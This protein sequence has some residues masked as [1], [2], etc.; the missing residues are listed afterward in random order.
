MKASAHSRVAPD[1]I[2]LTF[3]DGPSRWTPLA[4]DELARAETRATFFVTPGTDADLVLRMLADGHE[5]GYHCGEHVR[6]SERRRSEVRE[7]ARS[8][9]DWLEKLG[10]T[11]R[12]WRPPWGVLADWS[13]ELAAELDLEIWLWSDDTNDWDGRSTQ[14]M[15][16]DLA[17][18]IGPG[19]VVLMHDGLGPGCRRLDPMATVALI[20]PLVEL[21]RGLELQP[22]ILTESIAAHA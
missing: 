4:L 20:A 1:R 21:C 11:P 17:D 5:V 18:S 22:D 9:L 7:E 8:G 14:M 13:A 15:L 16:C 10:A 6:H 2:A 12:A 3:D 19:S